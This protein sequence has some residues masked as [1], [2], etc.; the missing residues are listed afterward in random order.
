MTGMFMAYV[1]ASSQH[2]FYIVTQ[3]ECE[4]EITHRGHRQFSD[5]DVIKQKLNCLNNLSTSMRFLACWY[6]R[7]VAQCLKG[8]YEDGERNLQYLKGTDEDS[9]RYVIIH[10]EKSGIEYSN[11][12]VMEQVF[13]RLN[14]MVTRIRFSAV[15][16]SWRWVAR[17]HRTSLVWLKLQTLDKS[18][19]QKF[20]SLSDG[21]TRTL[22]LPE[23]HGW[24][25]CGSFE[26]WLIMQTRLRRETE[27]FLLDS[28]SKVQIHLPVLQID[29]LLTGPFVPCGFI[30][31][32]AFLSSAPNSN[33]ADNT[34]CLIIA[35]DISNNLHVCRLGDK[36]WTCHH[37][38]NSLLKAFRHDRMLFHNRTAISLSFQ[39]SCIMVM[40]FD[41]HLDLRAKI[42]W[43]SPWIADFRL[44]TS[45]FLVEWRGELLL[46]FHVHGHNKAFHVYKI[47]SMW[48]L[49]EVES[50]GDGMIFLI[51]QQP[52][53]FSVRD[54]PALDLKGNC[55]YYRV[56]HQMHAFH[57]EAERSERCKSL[58]FWCL[59]TQW[60]LIFNPSKTHALDRS[61]DL[62]PI[63]RIYQASLSRALS[64]GQLFQ[65]R[66][67]MSNSSFGIPKSS[68]WA[69]FMA[70]ISYY[71]Y[72]GNLYG[73]S[74][75]VFSL[76]A[77]LAIISLLCIS[78]NLKED[79]FKKFMFLDE[80]TD[81]QLSFLKEY[82]KA[83]NDSFCA[84]FWC[85]IACFSLRSVHGIIC[86]PYI[87]DRPLLQ[88][89]V[90][91]SLSVVLWTYTH[92]VF[93]S[94][95]VLFY[96]VCELPVIPFKS[97][98]KFLDKERD[99]VVCVKELTDLRNRL[100]KI[101]G[102]F[103]SFLLISF[104]VI[105]ASQVV[106]LFQITK[107]HEVVNIINGGDFVI[108]SIVQVI[109]FILCLRA[110]STLSK[111]VQASYLWR[112]AI[113]MY[114]EASLDGLTIYGYKIDSDAV[115]I[116]LLFEVGLALGMQSLVFMALGILKLLRSKK[117]IRE[118]YR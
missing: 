6:W 116:I 48:N 22:R 45:R 16:G 98:D 100:S 84:I 2:K 78:H 80:L 42:H 92:T 72:D 113:D 7:L 103:S 118:Q 95:C 55:I 49:V 36:S 44:K 105:N 102:R 104:F 29:H 93:L 75:F 59:A 79:G 99:A 33:G 12:D 47:G 1:T 101:S 52:R 112:E 117:K 58:D 88:S 23:A 62:I 60:V 96:L 21:R 40:E 27:V 85:I 110:A 106:T 50:L 83:C 74:S 14:D 4:R 94:T 73:S 57:L 25:S 24:C 115:L 61:I 26:G 39:S 3:K 13:I 71:L 70:A 54:F 53:C 20:F 11:P 46:G 32:S 63:G 41:H 91:Q 67:G 87:I 76:N 51:T 17:G 56:N 66:K 108:S 90:M 97:F 34:N 18:D 107:Y 31:S 9:E 37:F 81:R 65:R 111:R 15:C 109:G 77:V 19:G 43:L 69:F 28:L 82:I 8:T 68:L 114:A 35:I 30:I 38:S 5:E 86:I 89:I 10:G 64:N